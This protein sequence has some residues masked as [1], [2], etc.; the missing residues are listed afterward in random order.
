MVSTYGYT[1]VAA[2]ESFASTDY[3]AVDSD[4]S[5]TVI[6][7]QITQAERLINSHMGTTYTGTIPDAIVAAALDISM[8][9]MYNRMIY[10]E[11][12]ENVQAQLIVDKT[13]LDILDAYKALSVG[14]KL[15]IKT[16]EGF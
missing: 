16:A 12:I 15:W 4:Y 14:R 9:L 1:T 7:A 2:L 10:D 6:E 8:R 13:I 3:S 11:H 5:D